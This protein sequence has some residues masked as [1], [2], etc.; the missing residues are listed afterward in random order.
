MTASTE[1]GLITDNNN[2]LAALNFSFNPANT[3]HYIDLR[4][5][6]LISLL[7]SLFSFSSIAQGK[8][9]KFIVGSEY[10]ELP[11]IKFEPTFNKSALE[12]GVFDD[13]PIHQPLLGFSFMATKDNNRFWELSI[14]SGTNNPREFSFFRPNVIH[15]VYAIENRHNYQANFSWHLFPRQANDRNLRYSLGLNLRYRYRFGELIPVPGTGLDIN[16]LKSVVHTISFGIFP[17]ARMQMGERLHLE[18]NT[19]F[20]FFQVG[21]ELSGN[22][23][24][25]FSQIRISNFANLLF[26]FGFAYQVEGKSIY[27]KR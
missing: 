16:Y 1:E 24:N 3:M 17:R 25:S 14:L 4:S 2:I 19:I 26:N 12:N 21:N 6:S 18:L 22:L 10:A 20:D 27:F 5:I 15:S 11:E 23:K 13:T 8:Y 9:F 7:F